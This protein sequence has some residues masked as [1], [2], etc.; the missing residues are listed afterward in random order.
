MAFGQRD[1]KS[2][3]FNVASDAADIRNHG[4]NV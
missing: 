4:A 1:L 2:G 3:H